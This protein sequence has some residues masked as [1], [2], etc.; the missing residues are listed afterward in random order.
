MKQMRMEGQV[1][2]IFLNLAELVILLKYRIT[3]IRG[4][5]HMMELRLTGLWESVVI[6]FKSH[7][8]WFGDFSVIVTPCD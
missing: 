5:N 6:T 1:H 7:K 4:N 8:K 2:R 3:L